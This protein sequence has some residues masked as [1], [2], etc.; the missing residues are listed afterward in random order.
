[1]GGGFGWIIHGREAPNRADYGL[2]P[3]RGHSRTLGHRGV[4]LLD[5][6]PEFTRSVLE[7]QRQLLEDGVVSVARV[8]GRG[9]VPGEVPARRDDEHLSSTAQPRGFVAGFYLNFLPIA[10]RNSTRRQEDRRD[11]SG[12]HKA[13]A[14]GCRPTLSAA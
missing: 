6:L 13:A 14:H 7:A 5:E 12:T 2:R 1:V 10:I 9:L 11:Q 4:P 3:F 8:G